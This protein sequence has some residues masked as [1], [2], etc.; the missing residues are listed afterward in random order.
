MTDLEKMGTISNFLETVDKL[1]NV[2]ARKKIIDLLEKQGIK[3]IVCSEEKVSEL[4]GMEWKSTKID[5]VE[6]ANE[7]FNDE[8]KENF[9]EICDEYD[10]EI[11]ICSKCG[12]IMVQGY[13][14]GDGES[15]YCGDDCL[16]SEMTKEEY[17]E[18]YDNG[19][20]DSYWTDWS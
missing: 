20:G 19:N 8:D 2:E 7:L 6:F 9:K 1:F 17:E 4:E 5:M 13:C 16:Y 14:I 3:D 15:Y 11:R 10:I 18:L 12:I